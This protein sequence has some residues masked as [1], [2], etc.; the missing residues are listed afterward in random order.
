MLIVRGIVGVAIFLGL[1]QSLNIC[2]A[3]TYTC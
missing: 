3:A 2:H 1:T